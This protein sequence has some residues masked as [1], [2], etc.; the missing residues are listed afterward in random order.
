MTMHA[1][2]V[3]DPRPVSEASIQR[4]IIQYLIHNRAPGVVYFHCPNGEARSPV[5]GSKLVALGVI[6]GVADL[7]LTLPPF[8]RSAY[9]ELKSVKGRQSP[10]QKAFAAAAV[11]SGALY[12]V[13]HSI[14]E[15][16]A[17]LIQWGALKPRKEA[18]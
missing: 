12:A 4:T 14:S 10:D 6:R 17:I 8:G 11:K 2:K 13:A 15:A 5:T 16:E 1:M 7:C 18:A 9:L 3:R